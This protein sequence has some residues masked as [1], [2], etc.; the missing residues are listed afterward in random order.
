MN[1]N[2][3]SIVNDEENNHFETADNKLPDG[4]EYD[5]F[6]ENTA[7]SRIKAEGMN[8]DYL[9]H[10]Y[11]EDMEFLNKDVRM[12]RTGYLRD[13]DTV[14]STYKKETKHAKMRLVFHTVIF[15]VAVA[16]AIY[17]CNQW[18]IYSGLYEKL[19]NFIYFNS[20]AARDDG[21]MRRAYWAASGLFGSLAVISFFVGLAQF[22]FFTISNVRALKLAKRIREK[23]VRNI[24][25]RKKE[26][27]LLGQYDASR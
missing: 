19:T 23:A 24:E 2:E 7:K 12:T 10:I 25:S 8:R 22:I 4:V 1:E 3:K 21:G 9:K 27:M 26:C 11:K 18:I 13:L 15:V 20:E 5:V 16:I 17:F 14:E 6:S